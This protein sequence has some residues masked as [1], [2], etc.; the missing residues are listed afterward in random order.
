M[1]DLTASNF[2]YEELGEILLPVE[3]NCPR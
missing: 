1:N 2:L 3:I